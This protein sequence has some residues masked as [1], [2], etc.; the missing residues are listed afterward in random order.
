MIVNDKFYDEF[1]DVVSKLGE[2]K[3]DLNENVGTSADGY[4]SVHGGWNL[5]LQPEIIVVTGR[6]IGEW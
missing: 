4:K 3:I 5:V 2:K 1:L 6:S